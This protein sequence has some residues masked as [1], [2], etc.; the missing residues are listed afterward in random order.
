LSKRDNLSKLLLTIIADDLDEAKKFKHPYIAC[1]VIACEIYGICE[2]LILNR[3]ILEQFWKFL[4]RP[5]PINPL[6]ASYFSKVN[7]VLIQKKAVEMAEF[8]KAQPDVISRIL[9]HIGNASVAE[10]LLKIISIEEVTE[11][12]G[13]VTWLSQ[14]GLIPNLVDRLDP[15]LEIEIHNTASQAILD[16]IAV[17]YQNVVAPIETAN[18]GISDQYSFGGNALVD[19][20]KSEVIMKKM[21]AFML[22]RNA[23]NATSTLA[24]GINIIIELIRRYCSEIEQAEYQ[25]HQSQQEGV[26][27][28]EGEIPSLEKVYALSVDLGDLL[29][30]VRERVKEFAGL[31]VNPRNL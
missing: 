24:N 15:N 18:G 23:P 10:L 26:T 27:S 3:D 5:S 1:E 20:L 14:E 19:E 30:A 13:I 11:G 21:V 28:T 9:F 22:D 16:I 7:G 4:D 31:L 6:Q 17:S 29:K 25:Q 8:I 12:Q 2:A